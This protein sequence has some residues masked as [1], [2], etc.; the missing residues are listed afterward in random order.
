MRRF[1][2]DQLYEDEGKTTGFW[3][4]RY[5][6]YERELGNIGVLDRPNTAKPHGVTTSTDVPGEVI[7]YVSTDINT[8]CFVGE[9]QQPAL[10]AGQ[11]WR[12]VTSKTYQKVDQAT[13]IG[14]FHLLVVDTLQ[15]QTKWNLVTRWVDW[16]AG[17]QEF[18]TRTQFATLAREDVEFVSDADRSKGN[19]DECRGLMP[20]AKIRLGD[21]GMVRICDLADLQEEHPRS[22]PHTSV[23]TGVGDGYYT[24]RVQRDSAGLISR[25]DVFFC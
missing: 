9:D 11:Y 24:T 23:M 16:A 8:I 6:A 5:R 20:V 21:N 7:G 22:R 4:G 12:A 10:E 13:N 1:T 2:L 25:I 19:Q 17:G 3:P 15:P 14:G 18:G